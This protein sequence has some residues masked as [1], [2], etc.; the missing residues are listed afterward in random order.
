[1][2]AWSTT[3]TFGGVFRSTDGGAHWEQLGSGLGGR[4]VFALAQTK[5]GAVVAGTSSGIFVFGPPADDPSPADGAKAAT[6]AGASALADPVSWQPRN[7]IANTVM[8]T[9][10]ETH[11]STRVNIEKQ[12]QAPAIELAEPVNAL[13]VSGDVWVAATNYGLLTSHDQG[14]TWQGGPVMG[15]GTTCLSPL[16]ATIW[17]QHAPMAWCC[18]RMPGN[19]GGR[20]ACPRCSR[21]FIVSSSRPM[22][23]SGWARARE[24]TIPRTWA[25]PGCGFIAFRFAMST[26]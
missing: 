26:T 7:T 1:M 25:K 14:A 2:R 11:M 13:D 24:S 15:E 19:P 22:A 8:K 4:D 5:D 12:V 9:I 6:R 18:Q 21:A 23:R 3:R 10:T 20:W 16:T 17:P